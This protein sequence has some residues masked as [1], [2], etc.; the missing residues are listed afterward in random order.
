MGFCPFASPRVLRIV[1]RGTGNNR[2]NCCALPASWLYGQAGARACVKA[3]ATE[4]W[5]TRLGRHVFFMQK[6]RTRHFLPAN[7]NKTK[8][9][10]VATQATLQQQRHQPLLLV[11]PPGLTLCSVVRDQA[12]PTLKTN[13]FDTVAFTEKMLPLVRK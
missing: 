11:L 4:A 8:A 12:E 1:C 13:F 9:T 5:L 3:V 7:V 6:Q 10:A 2:R